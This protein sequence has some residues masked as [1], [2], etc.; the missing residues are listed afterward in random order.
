MPTEVKGALAL[1]KALKKFEPDLAKETTKEIASFLKPIVSNARGFLPSNENVP[2]G[3]LKRENAGGRW[4][5]RYYDQSEARRGIT[6]KTSPS[7]ANRNGFRAL[8]SIFNKGAAGAIYETAGRKTSGQ[9]GNSANPEAGKEFIEQLNKAG[10]LV[11]ADT[12]KRAGRHSRK[13]IGRAM[14]KA[15]AMDQGKANAGIIKAIQSAEG[16]FNR[17]TS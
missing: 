16:A 12:A 5:T 7:K 17:R 10:E 13:S 9:Q 3:W 1:R 6:Y 8:A 2:S 15:Y 14:F 11:N 4:A